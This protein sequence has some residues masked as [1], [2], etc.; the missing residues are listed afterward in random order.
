M[1]SRY[2]WERLWQY[3]L[4]GLLAYALFGWLYMRY[5][6][7][8][9]FGTT[10]AH[11]T[12]VTRARQIANELG[13]AVNDWEARTS[14]NDSQS[15]VTRYYYTHNPHAEFVKLMAPVRFQV[16]L[17]SPASPQTIEI[18]LTGT[19]QLLRVRTPLASRDENDRQRGGPP[20]RNNPL[21]AAEPKAARNLNSGKSLPNAPFFQ[22]LNS[23][24]RM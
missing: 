24:K 2:R 12:A 7:A 1:N 4:I 17:K 11:V 10:F 19:G 9:Q 21:S 14:G 23:D 16:T 8:Q 6:P 20:P 3:A 15:E 18:N 22:K 5:S 13:F